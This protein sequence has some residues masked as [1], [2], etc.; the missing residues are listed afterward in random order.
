MVAAN[1]GSIVAERAIGLKMKV[2]AYDP[3]LTPE[4]A[5]SIGVEKVELETLFKRA[6]FV[7]LHTP[8][9][10]KTRNIVNADA[11]ALMKNGSYLIK[12]RA[13]RAGG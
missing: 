8:L 1:I 4:R 11:L 10:D 13:R 5:R 2:V 7:T 6:D 12:L 3:F 9:T